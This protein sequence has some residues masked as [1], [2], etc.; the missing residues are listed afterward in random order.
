MV[1]NVFLIALTYQIML[2]ATRPLV[3]LYADGLGASTATVGLLISTYAFFPLL[4]AISIGKMVD[5]F[6][7]RLPVT[8]GAAGLVVALALPYLSPSLWALFVSQGIVGISQIFINVALQNAMGK[9]ASKEKRD[10]N[11]SIFSLGISGGAMLGPVVGGVIG[12]HYGFAVAFLAATLFG[13]VPIAISLLLPRFLDGKEA[14]RDAQPSEGKFQTFALLKRPALRRA[15]ASSMLV[16]YSRDIYM[17]YF[18]LYASSIGIT[19]S[20]IGLIM[21]IQGGASV[22]VRG[23]LYWMTQRWGRDRVL[24]VSLFAAGLSFCIVPAFHQVYWFWGLA[25]LLGAGLGCGQP[26]SISITYSASPKGKTGETLGLRLAFNRL[27]Q[28]VAP[29]FFGLIGGVGGLASVFYASGAFLLGGSVLTRD[30]K[31]RDQSETDDD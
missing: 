14:K 21:T 15:L 9:S 28:V 22:V 11:I 23:A 13:V 29:F 4:F 27:S 30:K 5:R 20:A 2:N 24:F 1:R 7:I 26:L 8:V 3:S 31:R 16:L 19:A 6:G 17:A 25:V 18:P 10:R 12:D